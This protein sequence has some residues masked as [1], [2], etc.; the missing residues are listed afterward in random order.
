MNISV[1]SLPHKE[2][3]NDVFHRLPWQI[4]GLDLVKVLPAFFH[5]L[6]H[7]YDIIIFD[8]KDERRFK[9]NNK[10]NLKRINFFAIFN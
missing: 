1:R 4:A 5:C 3:F 9:L 8:N 10:L 2:V 7:T 6:V